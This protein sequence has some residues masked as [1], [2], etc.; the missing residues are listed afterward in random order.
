MSLDEAAGPPRLPIDLDTPP[1]IRVAVRVTR[2]DRA[3]ASHF[4]WRGVIIRAV[5]YTPAREQR[6]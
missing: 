2:R 4:G 3:G 1:W 6:L 5:L